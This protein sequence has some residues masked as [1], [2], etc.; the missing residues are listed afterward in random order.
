MAAPCIT[1]KL[2][3]SKS[4]IVS[5]CSKQATGGSKKG[6]SI[7]LKHSK[8]KVVIDIKREVHLIV[9]PEN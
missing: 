6:P 9:S 7:S 8:I 4:K 1:F 3:L 5:F 2:Y